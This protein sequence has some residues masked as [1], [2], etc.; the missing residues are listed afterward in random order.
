MYGTRAAGSGPSKMAPVMTQAVDI[1]VQLVIFVGL[2]F[3][4]LGSSD[5]FVGLYFRG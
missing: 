3:H 2:I 5:D 4:G 1:N